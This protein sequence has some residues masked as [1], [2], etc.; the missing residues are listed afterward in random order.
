MFV[1]LIGP[2]LGGCST[3]GYYRQAVAGHWE[4]T[5]RSEPIEQLIQDERTAPELKQR[6]QTVQDIRRFAI[7]ELKLPDNGSY[8]A[9]ADLQRD[10]VTWLVSAAPELSLEAER[11]CY[12]FV[13]CLTYRGYFRRA[14]AEQFAAGLRQ[15]GLETSIT[16]S[17]AYSTLGRFK[18]PVVNTMLVYDDLVLAGLLF[19]ELA[20]QVVYVNSDTMFSESFATMVEQVGR[21]HW[22]GAHGVA[23][24][25]RGD[26][27]RW[28]RQRLLQAREALSAIYSDDVADDEKRL[29]KTVVLSTLREDYRRWREDSHFAGYD[30]WF[31]DEG[32]NN[33]QLSLLATYQL[34]VPAFVA[35]LDQVEGDWNA[36]Y[37]QVRTLAALPLE[38]RHQRL[39]ELASQAPQ[40]DR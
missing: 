15:R 9:Y 34:Q 29:R 38:Q 32:P 16:P 20:H 28:V 39:E 14:A 36:F 6:L 24:P 26:Q 2:L 31:A 30:H 25:D 10:A 19:H 4:L 13:G 1:L 40:G 37:Q 17:P 7:D 33:A 11:W 3:V 22:A 27:G 21:Q 18:D 5:R 8:Q 23:A 35:L 12:L